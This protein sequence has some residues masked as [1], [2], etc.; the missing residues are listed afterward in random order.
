MS[1]MESLPPPKLPAGAATEDQQ[2][3]ASHHRKRSL[4]MR[5]T[6]AK[7]VLAAWMIVAVC[8]VTACDQAS[9]IKGAV[10][11]A[12]S[13]VAASVTLPAV[14]TRE[15]TTAASPDAATTP[16]EA[17]SDTSAPATETTAAGGGG[18]GGTTP[19]TAPAVA[20]TPATTPETTTTPAPGTSGTSYTWLWILLGVVALIGLIAGIIAWVSHSH[21]RRT[22]ATAERRQRLIDAYARGAA[23][24]DAMAA[25]E[26]PGALTAADAPARWYDIQRRADDYAQLLYMLRESTQDE[27][28]R[29]RI[30]NVLASLQ[31]ARSAMDAERGAEH[32]DGSLAAIVRDR[33]AF[34]AASLRQLRE[35][36][37]RP[38]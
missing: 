28:E 23:L 17:A 18:I 4:A 36:D 20:T 26:V 37:V 25:A 1:P 21:G 7:C 16:A 35:P 30:S 27:E 12:A 34:F 13:S 32:A 19:T 9:S 38:A 15:A 8:V 22:A 24:H 3:K 6:A 10:G 31:A 14:P 11:S 33:L 2:T 5:R 29:V